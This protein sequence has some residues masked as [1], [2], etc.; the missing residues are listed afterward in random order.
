M[1]IRA[2]ATCELFYYIARLLH[3]TVGMCCEGTFQLD[4]HNYN[5]EQ[6]IWLIAYSTVSA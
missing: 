4:E 2:V 1:I 5:L 6:C 3:K